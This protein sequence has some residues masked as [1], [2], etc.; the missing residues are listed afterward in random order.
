MKHADTPPTFPHLITFSENQGI[1]L[2]AFSR[3]SILSLSRRPGRHKFNGILAIPRPFGNPYL[4]GL[5]RPL[6]RVVSELF[7][8]SFV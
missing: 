6:A 8:A 2:H 1:V 4:A 3:P 7:C 5:S